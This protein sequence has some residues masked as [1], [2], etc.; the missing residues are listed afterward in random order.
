VTTLG[1]TI[2]A[3]RHKKGLTLAQI[4]EKLGI[5]A[6]FISDI[7]RGVRV[8]TAERLEQLAD[9]LGVPAHELCAEAGRLGETDLAY[10]QKNPTALALLAALRKARYG[11]KETEE[12]IRQVERKR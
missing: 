3:A 10:L 7:E 8:P 12:I 9:V 11:R 2:S 1:Q 4:G 6:S 5:G